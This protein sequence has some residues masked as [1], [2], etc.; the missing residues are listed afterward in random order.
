ML[1]AIGAGSVEELYAHLPE[2]VKLKN[3]LFFTIMVRGCQP[4]V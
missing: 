3:P 1:E 4:E 2:T